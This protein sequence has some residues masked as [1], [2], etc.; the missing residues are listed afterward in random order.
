MAGLVCHNAAMAI[1]WQDEGVVLSWRRHGESAAVIHALTAEHG[2]HAGL[3]RGGG[4]RRA[5]PL[6]QPGNRLRLTW[7]ARLADHLGQFTAEPMRLYAAGLLD[8]PM[9]LCALSSACALVAAGSAEREPNPRL[10][11]ALVDL[12]ERLPEEGFAERYVC[13]ELVL[14]AE[15]G[16]GLDLSACAV[17][18][19]NHDLAYVSP[20][21]G[22]AVSRDA[23]GAYADR[24]LPLP[25]FLVGQAPV[26]SEAI[27]DGLRLTG[28]L[29]RR[30]VLEP[31]GR[32]LPLARERLA[33]LLTPAK[34]M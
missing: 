8:D 32:T 20:R 10:Y 9:R 29:L 4:G 2:R 27:A 24:L 21:S 34:E 18:G 13:F 11:Q 23:A 16:F 33:A 22:R 31:H 25:A 15:L 12:L 19:Q 26:T 5:R 14:L 6:Y 17:T 28:S 1:E 3:V 7:R 30:H